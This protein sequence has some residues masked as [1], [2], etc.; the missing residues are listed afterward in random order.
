MDKNGQTLIDAFAKLNDDEV[1]QLVKQYRAEGMSIRAIQDLLNEGM[2]LVGDIYKQGRYFI[3]DLIF[4]GVIY[5]SILSLPEMQYRRTAKEGYLG[6][7]VIGTV[8]DDMHDLGKSIFSGALSVEGF[9]VID[10]GVDV[11]KITFINAVRQ[12]KPDILALSGIM[13]FSQTQIK[14][15]ISSLQHDNLLDGVFTIVGGNSSYA[16]I[17]PYLGANACGKDAF[18]GVDQCVNFVMEKYKK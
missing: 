2:K 15:I 1:M 6:T 8:K 5:S 14:E 10:L 4:S 18:T 7:V 11:P 17:L 16:D 12:Y 3:S 9:N 13:S